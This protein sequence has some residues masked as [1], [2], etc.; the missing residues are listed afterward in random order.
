MEDCQNDITD[1]RVYF[2]LA[3]Y[4]SGYFLKSI[5]N[6]IT[7]IDGGLKQVEEGN[8]EVH[9]SPQGQFEIRNVIHQFNAMEK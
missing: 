3:G 6:P 7:E 8:L 5:V 4:Y 2:L 1:C 9:I